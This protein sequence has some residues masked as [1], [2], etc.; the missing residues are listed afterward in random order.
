MLKAICVNATGLKEI[1]NFLALNHRLGGEHFTDE[2]IRAWARDA[3]F[4]IAEGNPAA[5]E[6][7]A[8][9]SV[10]GATLTYDISEDGQDWGEVWEAWEDGKRDEAE[11]FLV[12]LGGTF[13]VAEAGAAA[14]GVDVSESLNV[15]RV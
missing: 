12:P 9:D 4:Q 11:R 2:M 7:K 8:R 6:I 10:T 3:E 1:R 14:L 13:D 5:I 15:A